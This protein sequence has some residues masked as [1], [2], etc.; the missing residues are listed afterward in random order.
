MTF[1]FIRSARGKISFLMEHMV[2][3]CGLNPSVRNSTRSFTHS[4]LVSIKQYLSWL[5]TLVEKQCAEVHGSLMLSWTS[6]DKSEWGQSEKRQSVKQL[7][8][9]RNACVGDWWWNKYGISLNMRCL[10]SPDWKILFSGWNMTKVED[11]WNWELGSK[12]NKLRKMTLKHQ[13]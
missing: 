13:I 2:L 12:K 3:N 6:F 7:W 5:G 8:K 1:L 11:L 9:P 4:V 10:Y